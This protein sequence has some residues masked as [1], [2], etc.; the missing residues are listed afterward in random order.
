MLLVV[1]PIVYFLLLLFAPASD[2]RFLPVVGFTYAFAVAGVAWMAELISAAREEVRGWLLPALYVLLIVVTALV[3]VHRPAEISE[4]FRAD[5]FAITYI[6][7]EIRPLKS[8]P[9]A[10][11]SPDSGP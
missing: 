3:A 9:T 10:A 1:I 2:L 11:R 5:I 7:T 8:L 6:T 4:Y